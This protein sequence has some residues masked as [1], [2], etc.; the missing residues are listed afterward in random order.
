MRKFLD[1]LCDEWTE[2]SRSEA[3]VR[4]L[5]GWGDPAF[6]GLT[7]LEQ[8]VCAVQR[9]GRPEE[10]DRILLAL[11]RR[12]GADNLAARVVLQA[13]MPG[14]KTLMVAYQLTGEPE[15]VV[16]AVIE[17]AFERIR[18]YP[19]DRR[20][21]RVAANLLADTRQ[22]LWRHGC[23]ERSRRLT[24][25]PLTEA[26]E[27][28]LPVSP[29]E[30]SATDEL[31]DLVQDAVRRDRLPADGARLILLTRVLDVSVEELS[32]ATGDKSQTIRK[33]RRRAESQLASVVAA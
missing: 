16:T 21:A 15:E 13:L 7:D 4:V 19:C 24:C 29:S 30:R 14:L 12:A 11:L 10:S 31:V 28:R 23:R 8:V 25:V 9:R 26:V 20:P 18:H 5:A 3:A 6:E 22:T 17:A 33:R 1:L 27:E 32:V 2:L